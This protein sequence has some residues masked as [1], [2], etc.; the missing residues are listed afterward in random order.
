VLWT[1]FV[2]A[3]F[4]CIRNG[5]FDIEDEVEDDEPAEEQPGEPGDS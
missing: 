4:L 2:A 3:A 1:L 5:E